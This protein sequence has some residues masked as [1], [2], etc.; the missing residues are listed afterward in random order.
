M[1]RSTQIG[2]VVAY[3]SACAATHASMVYDGFSYSPGSYN[4]SNPLPAGG[5]GFANSPWAVPI[6][7]AEP[8]L[9]HPSAILP[10]G[11]R[12]A[13]TASGRG[14]NLSTVHFLPTDTYWASFLAN[15]FGNNGSVVL[16]FFG[17]GTLNVSS[18]GTAGLGRVEI[19]HAAFGQP[20]ITVASAPGSV[21]LNKTNF[22]LVRFSPRVG[23]QRVD[24][25]INPPSFDALG[26]PLLG[27]DTAV[28]NT[29][30]LAIQNGTLLTAIDEIRMD[31]SLSGVMVP[32]PGAVLP[33]LVGSVAL[34]HRRRRA[35]LTQP[36]SPRSA[37]P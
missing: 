9:T 15:Q 8:G 16:Q 27:V 4:F 22:V 12:A 33:L 6:T 14:F 1:K 20:P 30:G 26:T 36:D 35:S 13:A 34:L 21:A 32:A 28:L 19:L 25:W 11:G 37:H 29:T 3:V 24:C 31:G 5:T 23:G 18:Q 17:G 2:V 7:L 10:A